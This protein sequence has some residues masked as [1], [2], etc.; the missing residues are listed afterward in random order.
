MA[1]DRKQRI[2]VL[3]TDDPRKLLVEIDDDFVKEFFA[4]LGAAPHDEE[5]ISRKIEEII[6][7]YTDR[8]YEES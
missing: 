4:L 8:I 7:E 6:R 5:A 1:E 3:E 2:R